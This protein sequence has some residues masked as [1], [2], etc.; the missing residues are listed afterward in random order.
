[1]NFKK[2][3]KTNQY[4]DRHQERVAIGQILLLSIL[5]QIKFENLK[6]LLSLWKKITEQKSLHLRDEMK[7]QR[8][9]MKCQLAELRKKNITSENRLHGNTMGS[10]ECMSKKNK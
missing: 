10:V 2:S 9:V 4:I 5:P 7:T 1:M 6:T 8:E 3:S